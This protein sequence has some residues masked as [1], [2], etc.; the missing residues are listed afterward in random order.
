MKLQKLA[1]AS[2]I[3]LTTTAAFAANTAQ[4]TVQANVTSQ[5]TIS[6][7]PTTMN[8]GDVVPTT[9]A[10]NDVTYSTPQAV[11]IYDNNPASGTQISTSCGNGDASGNGCYICT[12]ADCTITTTRVL[13]TCTY[14]P[15][16]TGATPITI[17]PGSATASTNYIQ[18]IPAS[19]STPAA[20]TA[21]QGSFNCTLNKT[22]QMNTSGAYSGQLNINVSDA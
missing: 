16:G 7:M 3:A 12:G 1:L 11:S 4:V 13:L 19:S 21:A 2:L 8:F 17:T 20:C 22:G 10:T 6:G 14:T 15:C 18:T 5:A 9:L